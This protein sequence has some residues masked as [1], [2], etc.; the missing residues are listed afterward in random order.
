MVNFIQFRRRLLKNMECNVDFA[1]GLILTA[2]SLLDE[3]KNPSI[4]QVRAA[5]VAAIYVDVA[6]VLRL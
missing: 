4:E 1:P 2:K 3:N 6:V 5:I